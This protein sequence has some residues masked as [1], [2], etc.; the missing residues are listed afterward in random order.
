MKDNLALIALTHRAGQIAEAL[1]DEAFGRRDVTARQAQ[2][3]QA[4][5]QTER[6]N[7]TDIV[8][9]TGVDRSTLGNIC[10]RLAAKGLIT[11]RRSRQDERAILMKLTPE[12]EEVLKRAQS[13]AAKVARQVRERIAGID[14]VQIIE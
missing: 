7:Q 12:G 6:A 14:H 4:I 1:F 8:G 2:V 11:R 9:A 3:L 5:A 13:A 10:K